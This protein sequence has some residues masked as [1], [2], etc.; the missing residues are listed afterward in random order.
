MYSYP[1]QKKKTIA[2]NSNFPGEHA[3]N[4]PSW[5]ISAFSAFGIAHAPHLLSF[6]GYDRPFP[7][8]PALFL[9]SLFPASP[10]HKQAP[11]DWGESPSPTLSH[12][13]RSQSISNLLTINYWFILPSIIYFLFICGAQ[14]VLLYFL[15]YLFPLLN[16]RILAVRK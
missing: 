5:Y 6:V 1:F 12:V 4:R 3:P 14:P 9:V 8:S 11:S 15:S 13:S 10:Q 7:S 2:I 16:E